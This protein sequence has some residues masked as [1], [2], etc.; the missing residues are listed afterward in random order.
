[1]QE[2]TT[3]QKQMQQNILLYRTTDSSLLWTYAD[4]VSNILAYSSISTENNPLN[5]V[6]KYQDN[7][8][9]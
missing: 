8:K 3:L 4:T 9:I 7:S 5:Y 6:V 1:M 2:L